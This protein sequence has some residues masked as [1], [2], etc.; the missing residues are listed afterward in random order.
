MQAGPDSTGNLKYACKH[1]Q[2]N[3]PYIWNE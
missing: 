2:E 1:F 3:L